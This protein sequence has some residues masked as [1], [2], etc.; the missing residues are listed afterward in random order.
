[1][2]FTGQDSLN[3][4]G[5]LRFSFPSSGPNVVVSAAYESIA[6][7]SIAVVPEPLSYGIASAVALGAFA[8]YRRRTV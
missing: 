8:A 4:F 1:V 6:N 2:E 5:W 3:H 7:A